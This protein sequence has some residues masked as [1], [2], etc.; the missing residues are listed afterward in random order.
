MKRVTSIILALTISSSLMAQTQ[1]SKPT[2]SK[3]SSA[4]PSLIPR[5]AET[6]KKTEKQFQMKTPPAK[7]E[8]PTGPLNY[9][10]PGIIGFKGGEWVGYDQLLSLGQE[11][12]VIVELV[13][14]SIA[15]F[16]L[17]EDQVK[18]WVEERF[19][20]YA[21]T[22]DPNIKKFHAPLPSYHILIMVYPLDK[23]FVAYI[24]GR[25]LESVKPERVKIPEGT[26]FQAITWE[27]QNL[28]RAAS[29]DTFNEIQ[30]HVLLITDDFLGKYNYFNPP[31]DQAGKSS[32]PDFIPPEAAG[33]QPLSPP[34]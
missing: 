27:R 7:K 34:Q 17:T 31:K 6:P 10:S 23:Q 4:S 21:I 32:V 2:Q 14:P 33:D 16:N 20:K 25:L 8:G 24:S 28:I 9:F 12:D 18:H 13:K 29:K 22:P 1:S 30:R 3:P 15:T 19:K 26:I 11:I 5:P